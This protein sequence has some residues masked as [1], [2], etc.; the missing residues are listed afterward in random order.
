MR[1]CGVVSAHGTGF[2]DGFFTAQVLMISCVRSKVLILLF[3]LARAT[4][5]LDQGTKIR[6]EYG[7]L[8]RPDPD[9][10]LK[11]EVWFRHVRVVPG[12][13]SAALRYRAHRQKMQLRATRAASARAEGP[14]ALPHDTFT[15]RWT[16]L[17][18]KPLASDASGIWGAGLWL[19]VW[20]CN[21][22]CRRSRRRHG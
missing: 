18:P 15:T 19:G 7:L 5:A 10:T 17:G 21:C 6:S 4:L 11:R 16:S 3:L 12:Q 13:S 14:N 8:I 22:G 9:Q 2:C 20:S 1:H